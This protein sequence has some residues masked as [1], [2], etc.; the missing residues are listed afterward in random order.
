MKD[1][2]SRPRS[3]ALLATMALGA[4]TSGSSTSGFRYRPLRDA[5][6]GARSSEE[7]LYRARLWHDQGLQQYDEQGHGDGYHRQ[8]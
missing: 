1:R 7:S 6:A 2:P 3:L 8:P 4:C 5:G